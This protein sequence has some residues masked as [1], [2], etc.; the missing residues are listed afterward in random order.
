MLYRKLYCR[1]Y[2][3]MM[4]SSPEIWIAGFLVLVT[5]SCYDLGL[6]H[7]IMLWHN[8]NAVCTHS[9]NSPF[10]NVDSTSKPLFAV[11]TNGPSL[12]RARSVKW[13]FLRF[14]PLQFINKWFRDMRDTTLHISCVSGWH[15]I[16][17]YTNLNSVPLWFTVV[18]DMP[19]LRR[20]C[21]L[22]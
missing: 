12:Y 15:Y 13:L 22:R 6:R 4:Y 1:R 17:H 9:F 18:L 10:S 21:I 16:W 5:R 8:D 19:I 20:R 11:A 7:Y 2:W 3:W 14:R